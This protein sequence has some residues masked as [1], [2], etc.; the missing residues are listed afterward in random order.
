[1]RQRRKALL[2]LETLSRGGDQAFSVTRGHLTRQRSMYVG[3]ARPP[4]RADSELIED[5]DAPRA[6]WQG[7]PIGGTRSGDDDPWD[8]WHYFDFRGQP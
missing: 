1:V 2:V 3:L 8:L 6:V 5:E 7:R 4:P